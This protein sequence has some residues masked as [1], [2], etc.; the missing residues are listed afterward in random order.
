MPASAATVSASRHVQALDG[1]RGLAIAL[2]LLHNFNL[3]GPVGGALFSGLNA[4]FEVGWVGVQLFFV[5]SGFLIT[6]ILLDTRSEPGALRVFFARRLL[7]IFPLYYAVLTIRFVSL[8]VF[9]A[10]SPDLRAEDG[11][12]VWYWTY[13]SNWSSPF[14]RDVTGFGHFWSLA[15]EEQFYLLWPWIV[16][17]LHARAL[18]VLCAAL[19][20]VALLARCLMLA[21]G[22]SPEAVYSFT[23]TRVDALVA[24][25]AV[26]V[27]LRLPSPPALLRRCL[28][29][30][31]GAAVAGLGAVAL[32]THGLP[33]MAFPVQTFGLTLLTVAA[34]GWV[35]SLA[36]GDPSGGKIRSARVLAWRPLQA[37]GRIS[38]GVYVFHLPV[39]LWLLARLRP[40]LIAATPGGRLVRMTVYFPLA[41]AL[42]LLL[43]N[44][45]WRVLEQPFLRLKRHFVV[46][47]R[48][49]VEVR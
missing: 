7:R 41:T 19:M 37:L 9:G 18:L 22:A 29:P 45:S 34:A 38:Y 42:T 44:V 32:A 10:L 20:A 40:W 30:I 15:V 21:L 17:R 16:H 14:G 39:H 2:V 26:A 33:R 1:L 35:A 46:P 27:L 13:L 28:R 49:G 47:V 31:T 36:Q 12:Q 43:A 23:I 5:L 6:G 4:L 48:A 3:D 11:H 25:A 24:G 8:P